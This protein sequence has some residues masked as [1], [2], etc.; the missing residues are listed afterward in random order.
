MGQLIFPTNLAE[1]MGRVIAEV[2]NNQ[3]E[4][5]FVYGNQLDEVFLPYFVRLF[6]SS[7]VIY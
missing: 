7:C 1:K 5:S 3:W 6:I 2:S 4:R